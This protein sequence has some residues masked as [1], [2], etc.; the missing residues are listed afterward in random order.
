MN[1]ERQEANRQ[2]EQ[3]MDRENFSSSIQLNEG[4]TL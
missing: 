3:T 2:N 1:T 4:F